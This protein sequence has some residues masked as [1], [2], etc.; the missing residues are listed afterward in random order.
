MTPDEA[1]E[2]L[3]REMPDGVQWSFNASVNASD[4]GQ[5]TVW[6]IEFVRTYPRLNISW[7]GLNDIDMESAVSAAIAT[8]KGWTTQAPERDARGEGKEG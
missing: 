4:V 5:D 3:R 6:T 1:I 2:K 8:A 7:R